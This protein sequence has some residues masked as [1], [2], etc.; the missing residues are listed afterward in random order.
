[1]R[2]DGFRLERIALNYDQVEQY[3]P[4]P[5]PTKLS[6]TRAN[7]YVSKFGYESWEL[8]ALDPDI[9]VNLIQDKINSY[10][11]FN[12]W[13]EMIEL[14]NEHKEILKHIAENWESI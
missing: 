11:N 10:K 8:D 14:E 12:K 4:P 7:E 9:L 6:D 3:N 13:D 5:N 2:T 1:M